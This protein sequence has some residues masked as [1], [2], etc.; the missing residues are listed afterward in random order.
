MTGAVLVLLFSTT[1]SG[2]FD[3]VGEETSSD[4]AFSGFMKTLISIR[5]GR[6]LPMGA[7]N[8]DR[9][10]RRT[11]VVRRMRSIGVAQITVARRSGGLLKEIWCS[12]LVI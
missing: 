5:L 10:G 2:C 6:P 7:I 11:D 8:V 12:E 4:G 1:C 9:Q 3:I